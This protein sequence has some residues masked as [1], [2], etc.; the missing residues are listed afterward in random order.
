MLLLLHMRKTTRNGAD[1]GLSKGFTNGEA[2]RSVALRRA[3][4][5][6][7]SRHSNEGRKALV[8]WGLDAPNALAV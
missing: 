1:S 7:K 5:Q 6:Q 2:I 4:C 3:G 8:C